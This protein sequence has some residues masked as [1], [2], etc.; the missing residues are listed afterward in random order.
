MLYDVAGTR[1]VEIRLRSG[2]RF[3][4]GTD[5]PEKLIAAIRAGGVP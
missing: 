1:A 3:R 2:E 5:E 4:F